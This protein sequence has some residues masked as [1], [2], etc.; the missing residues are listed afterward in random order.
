MKDEEFVKL[1]HWLDSEF[2]M[3]HVMWAILFGLEVD[4]GLV[5]L[6]VVVYIIFSLIYAATRIQYVE[7]KHMGYL[8]LPKR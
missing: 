2:T 8:K 6:G 3:L 5:W 4:K 1:K 7:S